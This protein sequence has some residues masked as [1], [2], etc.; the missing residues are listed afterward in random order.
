MSQERDSMERELKDALS[1]ER[2][3]VKDLQREV[4]RL[5]VISI[6]TYHIYAQYMC[7]Q[8]CRHTNF[9]KSFVNVCS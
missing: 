2:E 1:V 3:T 8:Y 4:E 6:H 5:K 7:V 9:S